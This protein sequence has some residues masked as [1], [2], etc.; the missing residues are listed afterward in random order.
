MY[1][2]KYVI[3][4]STVGGD[5]ECHRCSDGRVRLIS[6]PQPPTTSSECSRRGTFSATRLRRSL[7]SSFS[8]QVTIGKFSEKVLLEI[9]R[10][11]LDA[12]PSL[13]PRL[14]HICRRWRR[15]VFAFQQALH[16][17][18]FC[19]HGTPFLKTLDHWPTLSIV[20]SFGGSPEL[21]PPAQEDE[22]N[23]TGALKQSSR[24]RSISLTVRSSLLGR[25]SVIDRPFSELEELILLSQD[26]VQLTL[27]SNFQWSPRLRI[28][29]VTR[30]AIPAFPQLLFFSRSLVDLQLHEVLDPWHVS[31]A[32]FVRALSGMTQLQSLSLHFLST[33][34]HTLSPL[35][36]GDRIIL[37]LLTRFNF[38]G[39]NAYLE[40]LVARIDS[41]GLKD[42]EITLFLKR[43]FDVSKLSEFIDRIG[44][45]KSHCR[46]DILSSERAISMSLT[47][48]GAPTCLKVQVLS[49]TLSGQVYSMAQICSHFSTFI[50]RVEDLCIN[51]TR[52]PRRQDDVDRGQWLDLMDSFTGVKWFYLAGNLSKNV[53][54]ALQP[55]ERWRKTV[56]PALH[57]LRIR[58][59]EPHDASLRKAVVSFVYSRRLSGGF[60]EAEYERPVANELLGKGTSYTLRWHYNLTC[61]SR[62]FFS[63]GSD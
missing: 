13:W 21:D 23:I 30:I 52:P 24:V 1:S 10:Y 12:S 4:R 50:F 2:P 63:A 36:S 56:L 22:D 25:F 46:A 54:L 16:L 42:I 49:E 60:L 9:F 32:K 28:L 20:V 62:S 8:Q 31:P 14:V 41:P 59:P 18:L 39:L 38:R 7:T 29:R 5:S 44:M 53:V 34:N 35:P 33:S 58:E 17:R 26:R 11:Y 51:L 19:T 48:P 15:I 57:K 61:L 40:G 6:P 27:P 45:Q 55:S 37:P 43:I 3:Q 47:Q